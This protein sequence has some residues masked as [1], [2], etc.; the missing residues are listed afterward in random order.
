M[1]SE[2]EAGKV[3]KSREGLVK[4]MVKYTNFILRAME[5]LWRV[6]S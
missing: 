5:R 4:A 1:N 6:L 3:V 2:D